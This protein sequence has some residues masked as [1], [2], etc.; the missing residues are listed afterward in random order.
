MDKIYSQIFQ[1][2]STPAAICLAD[3]PIFTILDANP[4]YLLAVKAEIGD[5]VGKSIFK[6][7]PDI[8]EDKN[9]GGGSTQLYSALKKVIDTNSEVKL[10]IIRYDITDPKSGEPIET[11]W[12]S[13]YV[14]L[15]D[16][17]G[18]VSR[19]L[20]KIEN[21]TEHVKSVVSPPTTSSLLDEV[22]LKFKNIFDLASEGIALVDLDLN[23]KEVNPKACKILEYSRW[24]ILKKN[25][26]QMIPPSDFDELEAG[27]KED[28]DNYKSEIR[29]YS[30]QG[31][32][33]WTFV[34]MNLV[35]KKDGE[36]FHYVA[37]LL[38]ITEKKEIELALQESEQ[39]YQS[40]FLNNPD[41]VFAFDMDGRFVSANEATLNL[42]ES[43]MES[44]IGSYF[45]PFIPF[46]DKRRVYENFLQASMGNPITYNTGLVSAKGT[47]R[48]LTVTNMPIKT[49]GKIIGVFGIAKDVTQKVKAE[50]IVQKTKDQYEQLISTI[51]GIVWEA[52]ENL[53]TIFISPQSQKILGFKPDQWYRNENFWMERIHPDDHQTFWMQFL[54]GMDKGS[55]FTFEYRMIG[56]SGQTVWFRNQVTVIKRPGR[57]TVLRGVMTDI[58]AGKITAQELEAQQGKLSKIME[59]SLDVICTI[60]EDAKF[61][62]LSDACERVWGYSKD[63]L[64][65]T[66]FY[67]YLHPDDYDNTVR[68]TGQILLGEDLKSHENRYI[69]K[70]GHEVPMIW[71][72]HYDPETRLI[73]SVASDITV[74]KAAEIKMQLNERRY[75]NLVQNGVD[76]IGIASQDAK[77][78]YISD[79]VEKVTGYK[80]EDLIG[81]S[82]DELIHPEDK[83]I[84]KEALQRIHTE[85]QV[86]IPPHRFVKKDGNFIW[87]DTS[88]T[89]LL[90][91]PAIEGL[92]FNSRDITQKIES[93]QAL[94][95]SEERH[96]LLFHSSPIPQWVFEE[97]TLKF[98]DVNQTAINK[99]GYSR[100]EFLSMTIKDIRPK[101][102]VS[103]LNKALN[104]YDPSNGVH[105]YGVH[106]HLKKDGTP[107]EVEIS[108]YDFHFYDKKGIMIVSVDVTERENALKR[109]QEHQKQLLTAQ[110]MA[111]M[112][113]WEVRMEDNRLYWSEGVYEICE[114]DKDERVSL[115]S[116][117][118]TVHSSDVNFVREEINH[119]LETGNP[120]DI[121]YRLELPQFR[122]KWVQSIGKVVKDESGNARIF[123]GTVQ[124]ITNRKK[125]EAELEES[126][127][128]YELVTY[129][130]SEAIYDW[131]LEK[132]DILFGEGFLKIF[133]YEKAPFNSLEEWG[134]MIH[135]M[136]QK[137]SLQSIAAFLSSTALHWECRYRFK[138]AHGEY[139]M[140][141]DKAM[142]IRNQNQE[143]IRLVGAMEDI[144][145]Q[146][147]HEDE[148]RLRIGS[149]DIFSEN[150]S[151]QDAL[152]KSLK[153]LLEFTELDYGEVWLPEKQDGSKLTLIG[154]AGKCDAGTNHQTMD[155]DKH[156][157]LPGN[158]WDN[159]KI[160]YFKDLTQNPL[161]LRKT[162]AKTNNL[163]SCVGY[164]MIFKDKVKGVMLLF[165]QNKNWEIEKTTPIYQNILDQLARDY[166]RKKTEHTLNLFFD[167]SEDILIISDF[168]GRIRKMNKAAE[169]KFGY[170][171][172][173]MKKITI[174]E[175][176]HPDDY[177]ASMKMMEACLAGHPVQQ[178]INRIRTKSGTTLKLSWTT[179]PGMDER[180][181]FSI[182]R[183]ITHL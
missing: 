94:K 163:E 183:V 16:N 82:G 71:S 26:K 68:A 7:F 169:E 88:A 84:L 179:S 90:D 36:P 147:S 32:I 80:P 92:V 125:A 44:L 19:I 21:V 166:I 148:D 67:N 159:K 14:P 89:N 59:R 164:P 58:T 86:T 83:H 55:N 60:D 91:D 15:F 175:A 144:S 129:A 13:V 170:S 150:V 120:L 72:A 180:L 87:V 5:L 136:D 116:F 49:G 121:E 133:G 24:E 85:K 142:A 46:D 145:K 12:E 35:R 6:A 54:E 117:F 62:D 132:E 114:M 81:K 107:I 113:Y 156:G 66:S 154:T 42:S 137:E 160:S 43:K 23:W 108:G 69:H 174:K 155:A 128:R 31:E 115:D 176:I 181:M 110:K 79:N 103:K 118:S 165:S 102:N 153:M 29:F 95:L 97:E 151:P 28:V 131:N 119:S 70:D 75:R 140:V 77:F 99:Y 3:D 167:L 51:D 158:V 34:S 135:P 50:Q 152:N 168:E 41:A 126:N 4:S 146:T 52:N 143:V 139:V 122:T 134:K 76:I 73:Y 20:A 78:I 56:S 9:V 161:F 130:T 39:R 171:E 112:G 106:T 172:A 65:G 30:K 124:D 57:A 37:H 182:A 47:E 96:R 48:T 98:L 111:Q 109:I 157:S 8:G 138:K 17:T 123:E 38:D 149:T 74:R 162:F 127:R 104:E 177:A 18:G 61:V 22:D 105:N 2:V 10:P 40:L 53:K 45:L 100:E 93:E 173:E 33:V 11:Y 64:A 63:E 1:H 178:F 141:L 27:L 25:F 101:E